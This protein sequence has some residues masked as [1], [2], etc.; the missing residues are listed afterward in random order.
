[1]DDSNDLDRKHARNDAERR[2]Q[3]RQWAEYVRTHPDEEWGR[4]VNTLVDS[5]IQSA[6]HHRN[7]GTRS[8]ADTEDTGQ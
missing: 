5:Q 2:C 3:I 8:R 6:R 4:Q 7:D 1:M